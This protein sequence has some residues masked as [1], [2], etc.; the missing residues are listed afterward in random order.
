MNNLQNILIPKSE[1]DIIN[2]LKKLNKKEL[3]NSILSAIY[4]DNINIVKLILT[5]SKPDST[6]QD[7][8]GWTVLFSACVKSSIE[9]I[10]LLL[11]Y[12]FDINTK[13][14]QGNTILMLIK[15]NE[16]LCQNKELI[17]FLI[18]NGAK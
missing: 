10:K 2:D 4:S 7:N 13:T 12:G 3:N 9:I 17:E 1:E 16:D 15:S 8:D 5:Y 14:Y 18:N 11:N 6:Y